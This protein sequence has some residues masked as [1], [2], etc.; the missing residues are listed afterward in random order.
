MKKIDIEKWEITQQKL[1]EDFFNEMQEKVLNQTIRKKTKVFKL[2]YV[3]HS[4]AI[5]V[6]FGLG[7]LVKNNQNTLNQ[8]ITNNTEYIQPIEV[9]EVKEQ[10]AKTIYISQKEEKPENYQITKN[11]TNVFE[12]DKNKNPSHKQQ[13]EEILNSMTYEE[14]AS[15]SSGYEQDMYLELY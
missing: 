3:W 14:L 7:W 5:L 6:I 15:L 2:N 4:A 13:I 1:P 9:N 12:K 8:R 10:T 11:K